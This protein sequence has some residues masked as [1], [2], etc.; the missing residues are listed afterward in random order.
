VSSKIWVT[1]H[2]TNCN[3]ATNPTMHKEHTLWEL[4]WEVNETMYTCLMDGSTVKDM[5]SCDSWEYP[6]EEQ[7]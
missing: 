6:K 3:L 4:G 7:L 2:C 1:P 5:H